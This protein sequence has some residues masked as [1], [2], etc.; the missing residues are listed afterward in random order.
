LFQGEGVER[1]WAKVVNELG[2]IPDE[3]TCIQ[4]L[5]TAGRHG[6]PALGEAALQA[7]KRLD[8]VWK[9]YH[10]APLIE[11]FCRAKPQALQEAFATLT[12]VRESGLVPTI[13]TARPI[14]DIVRADADALDNAWS[15]LDTLHGFGQ[16]IDVVALNVLIQAAVGLSDLQRAVGVYKSATNI[17]VSPDV[18]TFNLLLAGCI[19]ASHR[20][21]G[22]QLLRE[23][24]QLGVTPDARTYE[25]LVVLCLTQDNYEDAFFY[26]EEMKAQR[27]VPSPSVYDALIR[28]CVSVG[29]ARYEIAVEEMRESGYPISLE[30]SNYIKSNIG[31]RTAKQEEARAEL[32][33]EQKRAMFEAGEVQ[34]Q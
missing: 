16:T 7:L 19:G 25:R 11:A 21:L 20:S 9:E 23:M 12:L 30:L 28:K 14:F 17:S 18:E 1:S 29:D 2:V 4:V 10:F 13:E 15:V 33:L 6:L 3:G 24:Q 22:D 8:V 26:L 32:T 27:H 5:H 34:S 31:G